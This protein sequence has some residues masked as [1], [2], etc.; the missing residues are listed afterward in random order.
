MLYLPHTLNFFSPDSGSSN[1]CNYS[2]NSNDGDDDDDD[3]DAFCCVWVRARAAH[4]KAPKH[5]GHFWGNITHAI[6]AYSVRTLMHCILIYTV[7][8]KSDAK[9]QITITTAYLIRIKYPFSGFNY[10]LSDVNVA[11][12]NKIH[13]KAAKRI[14]NSDKICRSYSDLNFGVTFLEH[15]VCTISRAACRSYH[16]ATT[17]MDVS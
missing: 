1:M 17:C 7:F 16:V 2:K 15:S 11:N 8:Q 13:R 4:E 14:F 5:T 6:N 9:I 10:H 3:D 12:F